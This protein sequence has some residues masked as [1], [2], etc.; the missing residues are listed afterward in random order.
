MTARA[1]P[2]FKLRPYLP[3]DTPF[4]AEI[5]R[6][7]VEELTEDDY[8]L[9]QREAWASTAQDLEAF[10]ARLSKH[11][12]LVATLEGSVVGFISLDTPTDI[13]LF[14]VHPAAAGQGAG[15]MLY[16]AVEKIAASRGVS[17][18]SVDA[19]DS[20]QQFFA[21]RGFQAQQRNTV[22]VG[23]EWLTNT[24]MKKALAGKE[25]AS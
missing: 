13:G 4:L 14:Y 24:T 11:L 23:D 22:S 15:V 19:S 21:R 17:H 3:Q 7:S 20:A 16:D 8:S 1:H 6:A 25:R 18:L 10:A 2:Q 9:E 5:F 12:A